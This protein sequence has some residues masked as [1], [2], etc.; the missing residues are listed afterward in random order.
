[1]DSAAWSY[2]FMYLFSELDTLPESSSSEMHLGNNTHYQRAT[3]FCFTTI[4]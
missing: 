1:M 3:V 4:K 2:L